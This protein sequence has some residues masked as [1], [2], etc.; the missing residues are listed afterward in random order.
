MS[1]LYPARIFST[2]SRKTC[3]RSRSVTIIARGDAS[4]WRSML[5]GVPEQERDRDGRGEDEP[6]ADE[7]AERVRAQE[8]DEERDCEKTGHERHAEADG[9]DVRRAEELLR[10]PRVEQR[11]RSRAEDDRRREQERE[12][13]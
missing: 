13:R 7:P 5:D 9:Q 2:G 6:V 8:T 4:A 1:D 11:L 10:L 3:G 12:A